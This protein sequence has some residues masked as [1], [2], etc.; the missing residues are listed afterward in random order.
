MYTWSPPESGSSAGLS[1]RGHSS[2]NSKQ[3][4]EK[5]IHF[6]I[7]FFGSLFVSLTLSFEIQEVDI[8]PKKWGKGEGKFPQCPPPQYTFALLLR[9]KIRSL[10]INL[11]TLIVSGGKSNW[12]VSGGGGGRFAP[13][14]FL[15]FL[16][17]NSKEKLILCVS[18]DF[19][20]VWMNTFIGI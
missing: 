5:K 1:S 19:C 2:S 18:C 4:V 8:W 13:T 12:I 14:T 20:N 16:L 17:L 11:L 10:W 7:F 15:M 9:G 3:S 6:H